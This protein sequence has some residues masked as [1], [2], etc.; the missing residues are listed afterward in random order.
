MRMN[1]SIKQVTGVI[2]VTL[3]LIFAAIASLV[4]VHDTKRLMLDAFNRE[5]QIKV[6]VLGFSISRAIEKDDY[7]L[8]QYVVKRIKKDPVISAIEILDADGETIVRYP[9]SKDTDNALFVEPESPL[10][11]T[12]R[13]PLVSQKNI[14]LGQLLLVRSNEMINRSI[15]HEIGLGL[16]MLGILGTLFICLIFYFLNRIITSPL[17]Q[18]SQAIAAQ[19]SLDGKHLLIPFQ[20]RKDEIGKLAKAFGLVFAELSYTTTDLKRSEGRLQAILDHSPAIITL[21]DR[22]GQY[23][24]VN[25]VGEE[26]Y[27]V[28]GKAIGK[29]DYDIVSTA[30]AN[31]R[32]RHNQKILLTGAALDIEEVVTVGGQEYA[33]LTT[34]FP[35]INASNEATAVCCI[36]TDI[37]N[38]KMTE[39]NLARFAL[40]IDQVTETII[41][42]DKS[43]IVQYV[44]PAFEKVTGKEGGDVIGRHLDLFNLE[45]KEFSARDERWQVLN[46]GK[47]WQGRVVNKKKNGS[48]YE[49]ETIISPVRDKKGDIINF[50]AVSR[51]V[52]KEVRLEAQI[53]QGRKLKA[54]GELAAGIAHEIN[55]PI[56]YIGDNL[57]FT[58]E[59]FAVFTTMMAVTKKMLDSLSGESDVLESVK[60]AKELYGGLDIEYLVNE[61][62]LAIEQSLSGLF[63]VTEIITAMKNFAHPG[64]VNMTF[65]NLNTAITS[66]IAVARNEWKHVAEVV[67]DLDQNLPP[68]PCLPGELNQ[69]V[70]NFLINAVHAIKDVLKSSDGLEEQ[71]KITI[72]TKLAGEWVEIIISD[73]GTGIAE[74]DKLRI[75][76]PFFTTKDIGEGTGQGLAIAGNVIIQKHHGTID[77]DS[78][79]GKGTTFT[80]KL[81]LE[82]K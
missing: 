6:D 17:S 28:R 40:A 46:S 68:V 9:N 22:Q 37:T 48:L 13:F 7:E 58:Q 31:E 39:K 18:L 47:I 82:Q 23:L 66:T 50:V 29:T 64:E 56:Q 41:I 52:S 5:Q 75:F 62:P 63:R 14:I 26:L 67:T 49:T 24:L 65:I 19:S 72:S 4:M 81:P 42:T 34:K 78:T 69:V 55:T 2:V 54:I 36:S 74:E 51:D 79:L 71:G 38:R 30:M 21:Q 11:H 59:S 73:T 76:D 53:H 10:H 16:G 3:F 35:L 1:W 25:R 60:M 15:R 80:I 20:K 77:L 57:R 43:G 8:L 27:N 32:H 70:L 33:F 12:I 44:N 45:S 61:T